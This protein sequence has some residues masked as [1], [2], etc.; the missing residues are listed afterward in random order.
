MFSRKSLVAVA[1]LLFC[2]NCLAAQVQVAVASTQGHPLKNAL[3]IVQ[4]LGPPQREVFRELTNDAGEIAPQSLPPGLYRAISTYPYSEWQTSVR[5]F[6]VRDAE[7][8][9][10]SEHWGTT[11]AQGTTTLELSDQP[12]TLVVVY[13][14]RLYTFA[15][16]GVEAEQTLR[17]Q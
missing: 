2:A 14:D 17:L 9:L 15:I 16:S 1:C 3:V 7:A 11:D 10:H 13:H 12:S 5:E 6:L 8:H 4:E